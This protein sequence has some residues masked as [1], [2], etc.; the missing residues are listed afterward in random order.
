MQL[1]IMQRVFAAIY[2]I[3]EKLVL[4]SGSEYVKEPHT[5]DHQS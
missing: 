2:D 1:K 5:F 3:Y 4:Y